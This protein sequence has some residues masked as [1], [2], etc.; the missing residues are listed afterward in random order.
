MLGEIWSYLALCARAAI[1]L[2]LFSEPA[3]AEQYLCVPEKATGFSYDASK[4]EW[5]YAQFKTDHKYIIAPAGNG[6]DAFAFTKVGEKLP[7]GYCKDSFTKAGVLFCL[8]FE[9][10][11]RFN[12]KNGRYLMVFGDGYYTLGLPGFGESDEDVGTP[13]VEIGKC[14][15]F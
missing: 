12:K 10:D 4:R 9:G 1:C 15:L 8:S 6:R 14:S 13:M 11:L 5:D 7:Q 2:L 3:F